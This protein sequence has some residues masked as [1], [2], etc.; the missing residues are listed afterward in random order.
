[1]KTNTN[2]QSKTNLHLHITRV[3]NLSDLRMLECETITSPSFF[4]VARLNFNKYAY[5]AKDEQGAERAQR[6]IQRI[7]ERDYQRP[8]ILVQDN[9]RRKKPSL[10]LRIPAVQRLN[11]N[12]EFIA[13]A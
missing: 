2:I 13:A 12:C 3:N 4:K 10:T 7:A 5:Y 1:M 11:N 9:P 6:Y 8:V